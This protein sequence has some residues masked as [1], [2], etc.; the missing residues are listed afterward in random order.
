MPSQAEHWKYEIDA[1]LYSYIE[2]YAYH[3]VTI[4]VSDVKKTIVIAELPT[5]RI[6]TYTILLLN[7][8]RISKV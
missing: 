1:G 5:L 2:G 4:T 3:S 6:N 7:M 8:F